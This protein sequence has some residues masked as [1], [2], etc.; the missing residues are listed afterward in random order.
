MLVETLSLALEMELILKAMGNQLEVMV[1]AF[2]LVQGQVQ[3]QIKVV[4]MSRFQLVWV[5]HLQTAQQRVE[6]F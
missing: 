2:Q 6:M 1:A 3:L 5:F 4:A